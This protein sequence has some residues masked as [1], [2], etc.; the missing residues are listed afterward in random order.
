MFRKCKTRKSQQYMNR[1]VAA[2]MLVLRKVSMAMAPPTILKMP[3]SPAPK[4]FKITRVV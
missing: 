2:A 3:K 4:A 1:W